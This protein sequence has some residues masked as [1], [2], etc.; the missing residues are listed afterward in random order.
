MMK[1]HDQGNIDQRVYLEIIVSERESMNIMVRGAVSRQAD[2]ALV[3][4]EN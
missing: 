1:H 3:E 2:K 4:P